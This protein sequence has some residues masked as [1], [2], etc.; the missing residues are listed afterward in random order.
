MDISMGPLSIR[1]RMVVVI[2]IRP[3][4]VDNTA[5]VADG[6]HHAPALAAVGSSAV[7]SDTVVPL[8]SPASAG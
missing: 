1:S 7:V 3:Q 5:G 4:D 8:I 2:S 6:M